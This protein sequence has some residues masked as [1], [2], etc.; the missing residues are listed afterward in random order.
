MDALFS[1]TFF[2]R[3]PSTIAEISIGLSEYL[4]KNKVMISTLN[5]CSPFFASSYFLKLDTVSLHTL[6][7][8]CG[9]NFCGCA[10]PQNFRILYFIFYIYIL[11]EKTFLVLQKY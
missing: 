4:L 6:E 5:E 9:R 8:V 7:T 3:V 11:R 2:T 1:L 10:K